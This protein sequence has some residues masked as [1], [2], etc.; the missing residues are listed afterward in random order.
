MTDPTTP[1]ARLTRL[2]RRIPSSSG[3]HV[4]IPHF[5]PCGL[6]L[7][8]QSRPRAHAAMESII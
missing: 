8:G 6:G 3:T 4:G 7:L 5:V 1:R 2:A